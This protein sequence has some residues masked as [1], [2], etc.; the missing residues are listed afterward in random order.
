MIYCSIVLEP[1]LSL[2]LI[3]SSPRIN[4]MTIAAEFIPS[5]LLSSAQCILLNHTEKAC[6]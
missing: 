3:N 2:K 4:G 5:K 1:P 6:E